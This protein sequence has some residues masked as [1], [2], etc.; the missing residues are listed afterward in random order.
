MHVLGCRILARA[1]QNKKMGYMQPRAH[2]LDCH[3][4]ENCSIDPS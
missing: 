1:A 3:D 2:Q 4:I